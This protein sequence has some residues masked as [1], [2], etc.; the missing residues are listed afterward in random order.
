VGVSR[1]QLGFGVPSHKPPLRALFFDEAGRLWVEL[2]VPDGADR[3][4]HIYSPDGLL[5]RRVTWPRRV[6]LS[7]GAIRGDRVWGIHR[8]ELDIESVVRLTG[9]GASTPADG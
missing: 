7:R 4:A 2:N 9:P 1:G 8:N 6:D 3:R 5:E